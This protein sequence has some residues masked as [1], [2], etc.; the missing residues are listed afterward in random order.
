MHLYWRV[1]EE[2]KYLNETWTLLDSSLCRC[3]EQWVRKNAEALSLADRA[4]EPAPPNVFSYK[5][6]PFSLS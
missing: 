2:L 6:F 1:I 4:G 5:G 3:F